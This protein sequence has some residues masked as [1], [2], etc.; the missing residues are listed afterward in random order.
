[1]ATEIRDPKGRTWTVRRR[2]N[3]RPDRPILR[4]TLSRQTERWAPR[5]LF[6]AGAE[7]I[8]ELLAGALFVVGF[9]LLGV[10]VY[11]VVV[12]LALLAIDLTI[13]VVVAVTAVVG[14]LLFKRPWIVEATDGLHTE[15]WDVVGWRASGDHARLVA[16]QLRDG[17]P[18][19]ESGLASG[20]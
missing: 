4:H 10:F 16:Q 7:A 5:D 14:R 2:W 20:P 15:R 12:P 3:P 1:M 6:G 13:V 19:P 9:L 17:L 8:P 11:Y 18:L